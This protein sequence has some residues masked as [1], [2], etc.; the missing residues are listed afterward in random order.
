MQEVSRE[1]MSTCLD[2][3]DRWIPFVSMK[4]T[5][6]RCEVR[7]SEKAR[8]ASASAS[9]STNFTSK[10]FRLLFPQDVHVF[11]NGIASD[12]IQSRHGLFL[13]VGFWKV[14]V[15]RFGYRLIFDGLQLTVRFGNYVSGTKSPPPYRLRFSFSLPKRSNIKTDRRSK[16]STVDVLERRYPPA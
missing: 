7:A 11:A 10:L 12:V 1:S 3:F 13:L 16:A 4:K 8:L 15:A 9:H 14:V 5:D 6:R 2:I